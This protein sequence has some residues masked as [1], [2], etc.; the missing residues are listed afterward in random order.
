MAYIVHSPLCATYILEVI[1]NGYLKTC[2][3]CFTTEEP[4]VA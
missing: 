1:P 3:I 4:S 2:L